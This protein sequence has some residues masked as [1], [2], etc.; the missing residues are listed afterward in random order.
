MEKEKNRATFI[1]SD[2]KKPKDKKYS[3]KTQLK[4]ATRSIQV[5]LVANNIIGFKKVGFRSLLEEKN[6]FSIARK[7]TTRRERSLYLD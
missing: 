2:F 7:N 5:F 3:S 6:Q 4:P 1:S